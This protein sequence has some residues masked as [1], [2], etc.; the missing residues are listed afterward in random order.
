[1]STQ[2]KA[3]RIGKTANARWSSERALRRPDTRRKKI[4]TTVA[5]EGYAFLQR[6]ID[7]GKSDNLAGALDL[8]LQ[9]A[10]H[11]DNRERL[12]RMTAE[13]YE[14]MSPEAVAESKKIEK[15]LSRSTGEINLR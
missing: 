1:M 7:E 8:V 9:E 4:S 3:T 5:A 12:E 13:A 14:S 10:R 15:A 11:Q 6:L 2:R